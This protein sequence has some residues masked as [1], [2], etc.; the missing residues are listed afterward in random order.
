M[1]NDEL[2]RAAKKRAADEG[3]T[4][5]AILEKSLRAYLGPVAPRKAFR[6]KWR[7]GHP[8]KLRP[9]VPLDN[10]AALIDWMEKHG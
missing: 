7:P 3:T 6:L 5:K 10:T 2:L 4:L 1:L 9:G 8:G